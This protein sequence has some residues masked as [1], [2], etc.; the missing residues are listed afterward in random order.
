[1]RVFTDTHTH[2]LKDGADSITSTIDAGG[3]KPRKFLDPEHTWVKCNVIEKCHSTYLDV[4]ANPDWPLYSG[5]KS[6]SQHLQ[7]IKEYFYLKQKLT[8]NV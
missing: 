6:Y 5:M 3:N 1:M 7:E 8:H 4:L 2:R